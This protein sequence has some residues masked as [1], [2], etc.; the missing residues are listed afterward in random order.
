M[1]KPSLVRNRKY[2]LRY[3]LLIGCT[4]PYLVLTNTGYARLSLEDYNL[5]DFDSTSRENKATHLTNASVQKLHPQ[6]K[7]QKESTIMSMDMLRDYMLENKVSA[8]KEEFDNKVIHKI[9]EICRLVF[10]SVKDK[11]EQKYGCFELFGLDFM[12]D[13][14]LNPHL[15]EINVN[16]ALFTDTQVQ[17]GIMPKLVEDTIKI[18][19]EMHPPGQQNG[20]E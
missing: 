13:D 18:A 16:P 3:F 7:E 5:N 2:D 8:S 1:E 6:F 12:L 14:Q 19:T 10:E 9:D 11:L 20:N 17:K 15:I 4:K